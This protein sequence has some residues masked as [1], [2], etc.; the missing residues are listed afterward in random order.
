MWIRFRIHLKSLR[1]FL[2]NGHAAVTNP[3]LR[4]IVSEDRGMLVSLGGCKTVDRGVFDTSHMFSG[5]GLR[6][7][8]SHSVHAP[9]SF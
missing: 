7:I 4:Q 5:V 9:S 6:A 3:S 8:F 1:F 2:Q